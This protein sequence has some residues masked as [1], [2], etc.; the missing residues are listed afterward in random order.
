MATIGRFRCGKQAFEFCFSPLAW[1]VVPHAVSM[2]VTKGGKLLSQMRQN[3]AGDWTIS[4]VER[5]CAG[6]GWR[7]L[8]PSGGGSHWKVAAPD[9]AAIL[10][11]PARRPIKAIYIRKLLAMMDGRSDGEAN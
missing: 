11:I 7:C 4:D 10:T 8:P 6:L 2:Y 5:L 9:L 3:P 1:N